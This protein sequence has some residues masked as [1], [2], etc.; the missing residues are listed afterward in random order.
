M[1]FFFFFFFFFFVV[2][3]VFSIS[4]GWRFKQAIH[5]ILGILVLFMYSY[6][7]L[8]YLLFCIVLYPPIL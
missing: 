7:V 2:V 5:P 4:N 6:T 8:H 1:F 3:V